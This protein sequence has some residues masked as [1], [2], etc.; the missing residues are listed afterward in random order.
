[1]LLV[2]LAILPA[3]GII[4]YTGLETRRNTLAE[5][6]RDLSHLVDLLVSAQENLADQSRYMFETLAELPGIHNQDPAACNRIFDS[7]LRRMP[8]YAN[9]FSLDAKG[10]VIASGVPFKAINASDRKYFREAVE[11]RGFSVGEYAV[12]RTTGKSSLHFAYPVYNKDRDLLAVIGAAFDIQHFEMTYA[13]Q[14][15][16]KD[17]VLLIT[18]HTT[19]G[20]HPGAEPS[21]GRRRCSKP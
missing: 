2:F 6:K 11:T 7:L 16:P 15:M 13:R 14:G 1:M 3:L 8:H 18:D 5:A 12:S 20:T 17:S 21:P 4:L 19:R 9:V 10:N